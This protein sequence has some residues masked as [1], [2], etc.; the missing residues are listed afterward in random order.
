M[1]VIVDNIGQDSSIPVRRR[2]LIMVGL[3]HVFGLKMATLD[4]EKTS[5]LEVKLQIS[6]LHLQKQIH[7]TSKE[8]LKNDYL[9]LYNPTLI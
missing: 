4:S 9:V 3:R 7:D 2:M 5:F 1:C 8:R 6:Q